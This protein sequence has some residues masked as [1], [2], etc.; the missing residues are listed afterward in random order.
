MY[1]SRGLH[2]LTS[3]NYG[4][5]LGGIFLITAKNI[6]EVG[7]VNS[8]AELMK[9]RT[10]EFI[11]HGF[12]RLLWHHARCRWRPVRTSGTGYVDRN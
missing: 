7:L 4:T 11:A 3:G 2:S 6:S 8:A 9:F 10:V 5:A 1:Y 12:G